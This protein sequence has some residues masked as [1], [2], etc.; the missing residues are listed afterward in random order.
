MHGIKAGISHRSTRA[1]L[2]TCRFDGSTPRRIGG[3]LEPVT[4]ETA[5]CASHTWSQELLSHLPEGSRA[6]DSF[7]GEP[8]KIGIGNGAAFRRQLPG[9]PIAEGAPTVA[10]NPNAENVRARRDYAKAG[11]R[12]TGIVETSEGPVALMIFD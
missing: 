3:G 6:F 7:I 4:V 10:V 8:N 9:Q 12:L 11:F 5:V 2:M 1:V